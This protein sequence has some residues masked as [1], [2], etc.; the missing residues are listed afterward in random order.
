MPIRGVSAREDAR[1]TLPEGG[2]LRK[3][4]KKQGNRPG[5]DLTYFRFTSD[6]PEIEQAFVEAYGQK[7]D[8][9]NVYLPYSTMEENFSSW[10]ELWGQNNLLKLRCD[11]ACWTEWVEGPRKMR[12]EKECTLPCRDTLNRCPDCELV[13]AGRLAVILPELWEMGH[14]VTVTMETHGW[15]DIGYIS[16]KLL[17]YEP[18]AG[19]EFR[20]YRET[21]KVGAPIGNKRGAVD[22][23]LVKIELTQEWMLAQLEAQ[24]TEALALLTGGNGHDTVEGELVS[25]TPAE[26]DPEPE[27]AETG[28]EKRYLNPQEA[29]EIDVWAKKHALFNE[30]VL[31]VLGVDRLS[32]FLGTL[33]DA[34]ALLETW[35]AE[36]TR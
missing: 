36:Q 14:I 21:Q 33:D 15:N 16:N 27:P 12:G 20:L 28:T 7:P 19:K 1:P 6:D 2:K 17:M 10:R 31:K 35:L 30:E 3:G 5:A 11:G 22:K 32:A 26:S 9:L 4:A 18:L 24:R 23:S 13:P 8:S 29:H 34:M 25:T